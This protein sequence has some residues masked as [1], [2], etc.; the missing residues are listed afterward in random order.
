[1]IYEGKAISSPDTYRINSQIRAREVRL[2]N[3]GG[4]N[5][6]VPLNVALEMAEQKGLDLVEV[7]P[8]AAPPVVRIMDFNKFLYQ[9]QRRERE[10]RKQQKVIEVKEIQLEMKTTD[11]HLGFSVKK[12]RKWLETGMKV[13]A[14][15]RFRG[16]EI[17]H[18]DLG[19]QRLLAIIEELKDVSTIE[20]NPMLEGMN[21]SIVLAPLA[22]AGEKP[23]K[24]TQPNPT[25]QP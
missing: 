17:T 1:M 20:Q 23:K 13:R 4:E 18:S 21:M 6:V 15:L 12:A 10:A 14:R 9:R 22:G 3:D 7:S 11:Y 19:R 5:S 2:I 24:P 16:R 8:N 25:P